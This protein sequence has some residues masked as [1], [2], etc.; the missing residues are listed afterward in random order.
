MHFHIIGLAI[1]HVKPGAPGD[2][3][4]FKVIRDA[5]RGDYRGFRKPKEIGAAIYYLLTHCGVI[6]GSHALTWFGIMSY[7]SFNNEAWET[8]FPEVIEYLKPRKPECPHCGS[9]D[10]YAIMG[11]EYEI[12]DECHGPHQR[13]IISWDAF[14]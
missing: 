11:W 9:T 13:D 12:P 1:G 2:D 3:Y 8:H 6:Q 4:V 5:K 7:N 10:T 14:T